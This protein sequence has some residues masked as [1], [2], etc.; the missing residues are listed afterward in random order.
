MGHWLG[1]VQRFVVLRSFQAVDCEENFLGVRRPSPQI[2]QPAFA[3][4][5][6]D[7]GVSTIL[8]RYVGVTHGFFGMPGLLEKAKV[9]MDDAADACG[10][11]L[12]GK[13][14]R[15]QSS[16]PAKA[17]I[18]AVAATPERAWAINLYT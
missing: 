16:Q 17:T 6:T 10:M 18:D 12:G 13:P 1:R 15:A 9:A 3:P 2:C 7:E 11:Q 8:K 5:L 4:P 14:G